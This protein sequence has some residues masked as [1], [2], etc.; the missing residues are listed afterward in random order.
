MRLLANAGAHVTLLHHPVSSPL[1]INWHVTEACNYRCRYC[2]AKWQQ[3]DGHEVIRNPRATARL[4]EAL[5]AGFSDQDQSRR[6]RLNFAGGEPLL[7]GRQV[8]AA[9]ELSR[10]IG[11]DVSLITNASR[12]TIS[13][14]DSDRPTA[15][16]AGRQHRRELG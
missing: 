5:Y 13:L 7:F 9:M 16:H 4:L 6:P 12:L 8:A 15:V 11:F 14:A 2:Y 10:S 1:V 3:P